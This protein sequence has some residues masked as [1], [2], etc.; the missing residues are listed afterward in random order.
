MPTSEPG[1]SSSRVSRMRGRP[2]RGFSLLEML[3]VVAIIGIFVGVTVLSTDLVGL[4]RKMEQEARRLV[5]VLTFARDEA[6]LQSRDFGLY[7]CDDSYHLFAYEYDYEDWV[8]LESR[9]LEAKA[10]EPRRLE[11][12]IQLM[13]RMDDTEVLLDPEAQA[14]PPPAAELAEDLFQDYLEELPD[15]QIFVL[16]SGEI[17]PFQ[18]IFVNRADPFE[19]GI[20]LNVTFDGRFEVGR[21]VL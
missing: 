17:T 3:V 9:Q 8:P 19:P 13:L 1:T 18:L 5:T 20:V 11:P 16:T 10:Y 15:P 12:E 6:L 4:D 14:L 21:I 2:S 7:I